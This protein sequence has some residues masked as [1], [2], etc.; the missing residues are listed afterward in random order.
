MIESRKI[1]GT[2][3][4]DIVGWGGKGRMGK[5][6]Q[7][8]SNIYNKYHLPMSV[9]GWEWFSARHDCAAAIA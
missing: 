7:E 1:E 6:E 9:P 5:S 4:R 3:N 8:K 2:N